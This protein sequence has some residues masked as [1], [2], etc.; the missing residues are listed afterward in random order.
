VLRASRAASGQVP[1]SSLVVLEIGTACGD[2]AVPKARPASDVPAMKRLVFLLLAMVACSGADGIQGPQGIP[3]IQGIAG[4][5]GKDGAAGAAGIAGTN[6]T[7][8]TDGTGGVGTIGPQG[9]PGIKGDKGDVGA[10][11]PKGD[12]GAT[13]PAGSAGGTLGNVVNGDLL[14]NGRICIA[15][16]NAAC[17]AD[18][19]EQVQIAAQGSAAVLMRS[20]M[21]G[22]QFQNPAT[23]WGIWSLSSDGGM[24]II[25]NQRW[26]LT[27]QYYNFID[28]T[29]ATGMV[30]FDSMGE[31]SWSGQK[32]GQASLGTQRVVLR[33]DEANKLVYFA[34]WAEGWK[35]GVKTSSD[36]CKYCENLSWTFPTQ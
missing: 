34:L 31:W 7:N 21:A 23:H 9:I 5:A 16:F 11:G 8:G 1:R 33:T 13:G 2:R 6:G 18:A 26:S 10:P 4:P 20:N 29:R 22:S 17:I 15:D 12:T 24:R 19:E 25:Q 36:G 28:P 35:L 3:G 30:G 32:P 14:V 27:G